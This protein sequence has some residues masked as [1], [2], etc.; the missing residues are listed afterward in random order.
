MSKLTKAQAKAHQQ[1][2]DLLHKDV[3]SE[4]EKLFVLNNWQESAKHIN[5]IA[6]AF[7]TPIGLARDLSIEVN[8]DSV[9][10]L[11]AGIGALAFFCS[12]PHKAS[13]V[14]CVE[15]NP[16]YAAVGMKIVPEAHWIVGSVFELS[17]IGHFDFAIGNPPF[18]ATPRSGAV[19]PRYTGK[20]F[21]L[22]VIDVARDIADFGAFIVPQM[23]AGFKYSG[24]PAG[25]WPEMRKDG[26]G[27][28]FAD[29]KTDIHAKL[30]DQTGI[31]LEPSCG[32]DTSAYDRE[33]HGV[34]IRTEIVTVDFIGARE[35]TKP[36]QTDLFQEAAE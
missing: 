21:E 35:R 22:H 15:A 16:D 31:I 5:T 6:G 34:S 1:A 12:G 19:A 23:T 33:W 36:A 20:E 3:L 18:G 2:C 13:N 11:C 26:I 29:C 24:C 17:N 30:L 27:S 7:F 14:V 4:D 9:I 25:G 8:G 28:G 32:L 10:D